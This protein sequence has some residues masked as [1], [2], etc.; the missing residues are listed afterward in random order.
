MIAMGPKIARL[1]IRK[2]M[3]Q[4]D[5]SRET[6]IP[7]ANLSNI[8]RGKQDFLVSTL[9]KLCR[10]LGAEPAEVLT[11]GNETPP[12]SLTRARAE[13]L[14]KGVWDPQA[15]LSSDEREVKDLLSIL[16]P[17]V[18]KRRLSDRRVYQAWQR[19]REEFG[20]DEIKLLME[21]VREKKLH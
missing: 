1:R 11:Q 18:P 12:F 5:L 19:L 2:G 7:Q 13:R 3:T 8:E 9:L 4:A 6:G 10:A 21:K 15:P 14:T 17:E 20:P 16:I